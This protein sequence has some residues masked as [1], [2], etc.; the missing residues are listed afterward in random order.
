MKIDSS[1]RAE[2]LRRRLLEPGSPKVMGV[3][4]T[5][6]D[7]FSD[8][9]LFLSPG[10]ALERI[11]RMV[12][13]GADLIDIGGESTR[14]GSE[15]VTLQEELDRVL[16]VLERA[17]AAFPDML[18]SIDT[19]KYEVADEALRLGAHVVNDVSGL[20]KEPRLPDLCARYGA[21]YIL[22]HS[23]GE[24]RTMQIDPHYDDLIS[25]LKRFF[26]RGID[27]LNRSGRFP[28]ILDPGIGFGKTVA[29]NLL[30]LSELDK[31]ADFGYPLMI[32]ASRKSMIGELLDGRPADG[33]LAG[34]LAI[35]YHSLLKGAAFLRAH[36]VKETKDIVRIFQAIQAVQP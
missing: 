1:Q 19:T 35:H 10:A 31:F 16:P 27:T 14:P 34:T 21:G 26:D 9:G 17:V 32:G 24:P 7:S 30:I 12:E 4:N 15:P 5:T 18:F 6:P 23:R 33:R 29:H 13:E 20:G 8:G 3:L 36:D 28:V 22:M 25:E 2:L 11:A